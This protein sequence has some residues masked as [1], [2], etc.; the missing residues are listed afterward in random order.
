MKLEKTGKRNREK[1]G[2]NS[3]L[4]RPMDE[5]KRKEEES[6]KIPQKYG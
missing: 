5:R 1:L 3:Q 4:H 6:A 2:K